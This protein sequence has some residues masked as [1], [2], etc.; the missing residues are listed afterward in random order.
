MKFKV[1]A[2]CLLSSTS[3]AFSQASSLFVVIA[4]RGD[5]QRAPENTLASTRQALAD[6]VDYIEVDLRTSKD[7]QLL[8]MHDS[9][10]DRTTNGTGLV[11]ELDWKTLR[12]WV[13]SDAKH[14]EWGEFAIPSFKEVLDLVRDSQT[15]IY[16]DFKDADAAE[17]WKEIQKAHMD[18]RV[19]VY[20]NTPEQYR[21]WRMTAPQVPLIVSIPEKIH[22]AESMR[23]FLE[24]V[25]AEI[26]DGDAS[27]Y[28]AEMVLVAASKGRK[29]WADIQSY[30]EN[31]MRWERALETGLHGLQTDHPV[32][33]VQ[34]RKSLYL[35]RL[36]SKQ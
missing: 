1:S 9:K 30:D 2:W 10:V 33:M 16:L 13:V 7:G 19:V 6:S 36:K 27:Q 28:N 5:H 14:P 35:R 18:H 23:K 8:L 15:G 24:V 12:Q 4:H 17:A 26:L 32:E 20:I 22:D 34:F 3:L 25:D 21:V 11:R 29:V 31:P